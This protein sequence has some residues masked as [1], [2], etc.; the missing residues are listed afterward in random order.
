M[1]QFCDQVMVEMT[2]DSIFLFVVT[3]ITGIIV[4]SIV[5]LLIVKT[6]QLKNQSIRLLMYLSCVDIFNS[7][8][9]I[10]RVFTGFERTCY[11]NAIYFFLRRISI[12]LLLYLFLLSVVDRYLQ[13]KYLDEYPNVFTKNRFRLTIGLY[14]I[15]SVA[16]AI[17]I[18]F[19]STKNYIAYSF[20]LVFPVNALVSITVITLYFLSILKLKEYQR[21]N[22]NISEAIK[23]TV[24][25]TKVYLYLFVA[26][27]VVL[28]TTQA[29]K[30][31]IEPS[32]VLFKT[33]RKCTM[34]LPSIVG[35]INAIAFVIINPLPEI[36]FQESNV[37]GD[38]VAE[39]Q[40][41]TQTLKLTYTRQWS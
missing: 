41:F 36:S 5:I 6:N 4:N 15:I 38:V 12:C 29:L 2:P 18:G 11:G 32:G 37:I 16:Q 25:I 3:G 28:I 39:D 17:V 34:I 31:T 35:T 27:V 8:V 1:P 21:T 20:W 24:R 7:T 22:R 40:K 23:G 9:L 33:I 19:L 13:I 14:I 30:R 26:T 10:V